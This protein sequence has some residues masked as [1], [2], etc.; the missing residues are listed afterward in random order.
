[1]ISTQNSSQ[2]PLV[3]ER[4][5]TGGKSAYLTISSKSGAV[6]ATADC[7]RDPSITYIGEWRTP[8]SR[9]N[10]TL[11]NQARI[12][13]S[14]AM[15]GLH[16]CSEVIRRFC[17]QAPCIHCTRVYSEGLLCTVVIPRQGTSEIKH[18][19]PSQGRLTSL[20]QT[21][22]ITLAEPSVNISHHELAY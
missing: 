15:A 21:P 10:C 13:L 11:R 19:P 18:P 9:N 1:M 8:C 3:G 6:R 17:R 16:S 7:S 2:P 12:V 14:K 4:E 5:S 22:S 20:G